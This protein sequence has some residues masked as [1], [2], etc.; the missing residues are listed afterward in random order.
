MAY[1]KVIRCNRCGQ[2][3]RNDGTTEKPVWVCNN[4]QKPCVKYKPPVTQEP[5]D[6]Q[7]AG[8]DG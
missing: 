5:S 3:C 8:V 4:S 2:P 1:V 6:N 7:E